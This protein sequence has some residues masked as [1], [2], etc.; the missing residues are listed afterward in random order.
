M[1]S[2]IAMLCFL[3]VLMFLLAGCEKGGP[4]KYEYTII[5]KDNHIE[6]NK[7]LKWYTSNGWEFLAVGNS[8]DKS[9][10]IILRGRPSSINLK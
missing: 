3:P 6:L 9:P 8:Y 10:F 5:S 7:E 2:R 1:K 4:A